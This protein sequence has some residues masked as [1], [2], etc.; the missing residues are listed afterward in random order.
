M[1][2]SSNTYLQGYILSFGITRRQRCI[3]SLDISSS[4]Y[5]ISIHSSQPSTGSVDSGPRSG[6]TICENPEMGV[7]VVQRF[8]PVGSVGWEDQSVGGSMLCYFLGW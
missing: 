4:L 7:S 3:Q 8:F 5:T 2:V 1:S 6:R